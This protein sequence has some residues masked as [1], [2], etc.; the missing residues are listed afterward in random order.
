MFRIKH[1]DAIEL[2]HQICRLFKCDQL[3]VSGLANA[4]CFESRPMDAA[5]MVISYIY[6]NGLQSSETQYAEFFDKYNTIFTYPEENDA[7]N[8]VQ[9]YIE[10]LTRIVEDYL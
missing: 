10:E 2:E 3:G 8:E 6:A 1:S 9:N 5:I 7:N 4:Y